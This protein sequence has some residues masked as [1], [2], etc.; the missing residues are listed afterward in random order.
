MY[1]KINSYQQ[2]NLK[3]NIKVIVYQDFQGDLLT[4]YS[5]VSWVLDSNIQVIGNWDNRSSHSRLIIS[6]KSHLETFELPEVLVFFCFFVVIFKSFI[7][8]KKA[9]LFRVQ[10]MAENKLIF[11]GSIIGSNIGSNIGSKIGSNT[12]S[13]ISSNIG[14]LVHI[15]KL[16]QCDPIIE[17][18]QINFFSA[19][20]IQEKK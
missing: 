13:N 19:Q 7:K 8:I 3:S 6:L 20:S 5:F 16:N 11:N 14:S 10:S 9:K 17:L 18:V 4:Y 15:W 12:S 1:K 2:K